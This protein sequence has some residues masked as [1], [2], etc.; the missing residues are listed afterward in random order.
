M[1]T[2]WL[3]T[4]LMCG[5]VAPVQETHDPREWGAMGILVADHGNGQYVPSM[6]T[7]KEGA[8]I[9]WQDDSGSD[10]DIAVQMVTTDGRKL[11]GNT[12]MRLGREGIQTN[13]C[14]AGNRVVFRESLNGN[15]WS[16]VSLRVSTDTISETLI[17]EARGGVAELSAIATPEGTVITWIAD[18]ATRAIT[19]AFVDDTAL[20][21][22]TI[23]AHAGALMDVRVCRN[24]DVVFWAWTDWRDEMH[25]HVYA[26]SYDTTNRQWLFP[27]NGMDVTPNANFASNARLSE[28][29][30]GYVA[31]TY[32][33]LQSDGRT[34][35]RFQ[36]LDV[37][38]NFR[39]WPAKTITVTSGSLRTHASTAFQDNTFIAWSQNDSLCSVIRDFSGHNVG[40]S[41]AHRLPA[42]LIDDLQAVA[43]E[44]FVYTAWTDDRNGRDNET[45]Y[46]QAFNNTNTARWAQDGVG[47]SDTA[48]PQ[49]KAAVL[50]GADGSCIVSWL[51]YRV[52]GDN[53][54]VAMQ[55]LQ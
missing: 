54:A 31:I 51:D 46:V 2:A 9:A 53:P 26:Q 38:G 39:F 33:E 28:S 49:R 14:I 50:L 1:F 23:C 8:V 22:A 43:S 35:L 21:V 15:D 7:H 30:P 3:Y 55:K 24:N 19:A 34:A 16:V 42:K 41:W 20:N 32:R 4:L 17:A 11:F 10:P 36:I 18:S 45:V 37:Q 29:E 48:M 47:V 52:G 27:V 25:P 12:G 6:Q 5:Q 44:T 40:M 13:P